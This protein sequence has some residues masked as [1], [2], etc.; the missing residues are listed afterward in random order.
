MLSP[1][2]KQR[3]RAS[4]DFLTHLFH[5]GTSLRQKA[6]DEAKSLAGNIDELPENLDQRLVYMNERIAGSQSNR[7][8]RLTG[9]WHARN[10][11]AIATAAFEEIQDDLQPGLDALTNGSA[12]LHLDPGMNAPAYWKNVEFHRTE[13]CWDGASMVVARGR[14]DRRGFGRGS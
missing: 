2:L 9:D 5:G 10:H 4:V 11:G 3:G 8:K 14:S 1:K 13:G 12:E 7:I 6:E